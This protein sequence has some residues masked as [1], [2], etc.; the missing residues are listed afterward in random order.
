MGISLVLWMNN[1]YIMKIVFYCLQKYTFCTK[2]QRLKVIYQNKMN[3]II[4]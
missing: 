4:L 3:F 1:N 2:H